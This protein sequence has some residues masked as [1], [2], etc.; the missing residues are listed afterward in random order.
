M[1]KDID[2]VLGSHT[3]IFG[4]NI[5]PLALKLE[6]NVVLKE[7]FKNH[8]LRYFGSPKFQTTQIASC[9]YPP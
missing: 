5:N 9:E 2:R 7:C 1:T 6:P 8:F 3:L 4:L